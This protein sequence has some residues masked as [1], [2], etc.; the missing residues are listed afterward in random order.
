L[1]AAL[2]RFVFGPMGWMLPFS[3]ARVFARPLAAILWWA[4]VRRAITEQNLR[5]AFPEWSEKERRRVARAS[6]HNLFTVFLEFPLLR[7]LSD[8]GLR[9]R[10]KVENLDLLRSIGP[11]GAL[12]LS[13]HFGN[14]E[15]LALGASAI[16]GVPFTIVVKEQ[17]DYGQ[18]QKMRAS[19]GNRLI[20]TSRAARETSG[21]LRS[22]GVIAM[23]ADQSASGRDALVDMFGIPTYSFSAPARLALRYRPRI[24][25]GFAVRGSDGGYTVRLEEIPHA[26]LP[27]TEEGARLLTQRYIDRLEGAIREHPEQWVWQ[28]RKWKSSPG[29]SYEKGK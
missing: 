12:L 19:R 17:R 18:L 29:V 2:W 27:D 24:I 21:I 15:L 16:S 20:P 26:D 5:L 8:A 3:S 9:R 23:L 13:A 28:H 6:F 25:A 22:G 7:H 4:G 1:N 14:W 10:L 11:E